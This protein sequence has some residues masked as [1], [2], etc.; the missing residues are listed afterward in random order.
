[1][2]EFN[3]EGGKK[4]SNQAI[5]KYEAYPHLKNFFKNEKTVCIKLTWQKKKI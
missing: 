3:T 2:C 4:P 1:M 5:S